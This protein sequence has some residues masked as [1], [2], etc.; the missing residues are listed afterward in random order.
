[1]RMG[2]IRNHYVGRTFIQ[3]QQSIR[4]FGV[5]REAEPG[6]QHPRGQARRARRRLD[7]ARHDEPEDREDGQAAGA[8][9]KCTCGSAVRRRSRRASTASTRRSRSELIAATHTLEEIRKY[10]EADTPRLSE[11]R[12]PAAR[13][14]RRQQSRTARRATPASTR[15]R[16]RATS[17]RTCSSRS[18][19]STERCAR[20]VAASAAVARG[21][22]SL[23]LP[24]AAGRPRVRR[25]PRRARRRRR[26]AAQ[27]AGGHRQ[28][29][30]RSTSPTRIGGG[31]NRARAPSRRMAVPAL[32]EAASS[33]RRRLRPLP[34]AGAALRL[35]RSAHARRHA[36]RAR[37]AERSPAHGR[38]RLLRAQPRSGC[39]AAAARR[40]STP[41]TSEFVRPALT[42]ALAAYGDDP[43]RPGGDDGLV[44]E[45]AGLLPQRASSRR[46]AT[47]RRPTR[48]RRSSR[49][50]SSTARCRTTPSLALGQDRRQARRSTTLAGLQRTAP[51][52]VAAGDRRGDLPARRQLRVAPDVTSSTR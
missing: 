18:R 49:S 7:R 19:S 37:R 52:D 27:L 44:H 26:H 47:T 5:Q 48:S 16:S 20:C 22:A 15:S 9:A 33:A 39:R 17:R 11:P 10:I 28:A 31:A 25:P 41:R 29:R 32:I 2:L 50:R 6:A 36:R 12:R 24:G 1:M 30:Q 3:P 21:A 4:H 35:Q 43:K 40:R 46:S 45:R 14:R 13:R 34:R 23:R 51:R 8:Q 42:R 38:L